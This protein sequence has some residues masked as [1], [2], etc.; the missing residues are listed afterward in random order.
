MKHQVARNAIY[1]INRDVRFSKNKQIYKT[2]FGAAIVPS[3]KKMESPSYHVHL[4]F[5]GTMMVAGGLY[6]I[7]PPQLDRIRTAIDRQPKKLRDILAAP[8][9]QKTFGGLD[10]DSVLSRPPR[11]YAADHP[12]IDL[13]KLKHY[14]AW[15]EVPVPAGDWVVKATAMAKILYPLIEYLRAAL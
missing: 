13:L 14:A 15:T 10:M 3:G 8:A 5:D 2:N 1:R 9:F 7:M 12:A 6:M 4:D 11:G